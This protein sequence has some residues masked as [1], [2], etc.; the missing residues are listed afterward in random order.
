MRLPAGAERETQ[1]SLKF[2]S[3]TKAKSTNERSQRR[4]KVGVRLHSAL[5]T[6]LFVALLQTFSLL[7]RS[8]TG[9]AEAQEV[10][11]EEKRF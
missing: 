4:M 6:A 10:K 2:S 3:I 9:G 1:A 8:A 11:P 5:K 7:L